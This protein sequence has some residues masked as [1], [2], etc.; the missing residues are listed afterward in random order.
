M[1]LCETDEFGKIIGGFTSHNWH[2]PA[3]GQW[4]PAENNSDQHFM[5][6]LTNNDKFVIT[7]N[8]QCCIYLTNDDS[9]GPVFGAGHDLRIYNK[10]NENTNS[11]ANINQTYTNGKYTCNDTASHVRFAGAYEFRVK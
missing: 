5:F 8:P 6:S 1:I 3:S 11:Y 4:V 10:A 7:Q 2:K 9:Y